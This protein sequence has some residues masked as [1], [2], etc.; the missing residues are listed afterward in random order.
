MDKYLIIGGTGFVGKHFCRN[1][2]EGSFVATGRDYNVNNIEKMR[3]LIKALQPNLIL[4][5]AAITTLK[6]S[7]ENPEET[8]EVNFLGV[9]NL[10]SILTDE[11]FTGRVLFVSSSEI[12][13]IKTSDELP[14][15]ELSPA[16]P[17]SPYAKWKYEA[18]KLCIDYA[19][20]GMFEILI[21]RPFN[22]IGPGQSERFA[23]ANFCRQSVLIQRK[24]L[25][26]IFLVGNIDT[27]RDFTDVRDICRAY[28]LLLKNGEN[29]NIYN[30]CSGKER[31]IRSLLELIVDLVDIDIRIQ[32]DPSRFRDID[33]KRIFG[34]NSKIK[35]EVGW[36]PV[37]EINETL[38]D[39]INFWQS[40][41]S[42]N[43]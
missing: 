10:F 34:D 5:L 25:K 40:D 6:E 37:I 8:K 20:R 16:I 32:E 11:G 41:L 23:I 33:Q 31:S 13:G 22:H 29:S 3:S 9:S 4:Y 2:E 7:F 26:P 1:L 39:I 28:K 43:E 42:L 30:I 19:R 27:T 21:A 15:D 35:K 17:A 18:E 24:Q 38:S 14:I 36:T 12:Y